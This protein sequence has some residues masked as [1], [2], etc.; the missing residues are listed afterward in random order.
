V[1]WQIR[2]E[3]KLGCLV[4]GKYADLVVLE[5]NLFDVA[6]DKVA[7]VEVV[8]TLMDGEFTYRNGV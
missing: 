3:D 4:V 7:D 5:D 1:A 6:P 8:A 2:M